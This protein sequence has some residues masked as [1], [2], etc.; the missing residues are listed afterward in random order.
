MKLVASGEG[1]CEC[2]NTEFEELKFGA[3]HVFALGI[4]QLLL[5]RTVLFRNDLDLLSVSLI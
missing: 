2:F 4:L 3:D 1:E 5:M